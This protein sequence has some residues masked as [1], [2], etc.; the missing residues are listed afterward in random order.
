MDLTLDLV[1]KICGSH[2]TLLTRCP[3]L[4]RKTILWEGG[5]ETEVGIASRGYIIQC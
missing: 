2:L 5:R 1:G 4:T 3:T